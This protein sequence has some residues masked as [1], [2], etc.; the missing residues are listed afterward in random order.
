MVQSQGGNFNEKSDTTG[1]NIGY[2][3]QTK[4][5]M[6]PN[7]LLESDMRDGHGII[8]YCAYLGPCKVELPDCSDYAWYDKWN[9]TKQ[10]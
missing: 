9:M 8:L 6:S 10:K 1:G 5:L 4:P 3:Q 7:E 2:S